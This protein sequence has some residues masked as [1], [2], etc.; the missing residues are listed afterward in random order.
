MSGLGLGL[1]LTSRAAAGGTIA[2]SVMLDSASVAEDANVGDL[3]GNLSVVGGSGSYTF[4]ITADPDSKF[5]LDG[6]DD[7]ILEVGGALDYETATS[8][9][10]T[11]EADNGVDDPISRQFT[12]QVTNVVETA[13]AQ[14]GAG[15]WSVADLGTNGDIAIT[16]ATLPDPGDGPITDLEYQVDGGGWSSLGDVVTGA[17]PLSGFTDGTE[18]DI[19]I[20]AVNAAGNGTASATK[21]VTPTGIPDAFEAADW[22]V[23][24]ATTGGQLDVTISSLPAANGS[25]VTDIEYRV[26]GG[27]WVSSGGTTDFSITGLTDDVEVDV[28]LQ[29][30]NANGDSG[31]GDLKSETPTTAGGGAPVVAWGTGEYGF[32]GD[33]IAVTSGDTTGNWQSSA[34]GST[35]WANISGETT[36]AGF[37][38]TAAYEG[39][40]VRWNDDT[41]GASNVPDRVWVPPDLGTSILKAYTD[42]ANEAEI[43]E[44]GGDVSQVDDVSGNGNDYAQGTGSLQPKTGTVALNS[45]NCLDFN[46]DY[47]GRADALGFTGSPAVTIVTLSQ[48]DTLADKAAVSVGQTGND[49][50]IAACPGEAKISFG[51]STVTF[52]DG[53]A[54][55]ATWLI[56]LF[57]HP[58]S[59]THENSYV[60]RNGTLLSLQSSSNGGN[61]LSM[62]DSLS[63]IGAFVGGAGGIRY[64]VALVMVL[65][66]EVSTA[67]REK[68]EGFIAHRYA[69]EGDL[70][71]GHTYKS[72]PPTV[73]AL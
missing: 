71:G 16:I 34:D 32:I 10:V 25:A 29:A 55:G 35:G 26:E 22:S 44:S 27:S 5:Q 72:T 42:F 24:D 31:A 68:I 17:Y 13:P 63:K 73:E 53:A 67:N 9:T 54:D 30:V 11:I 60:Y 51:G 45:L 33:V 56:D 12:I 58:A 61:S 70:P 46:Q 43:T 50:M 15:D 48:P 49:G 23:A 21:A 1:G 65:A 14:F 57:V 6:G 7:S 47:L 69:M 40:F 18:Y 8:H 2:A 20:R 19:A 28:E 36:A 38:Q 52:D 39:T 3:V 66:S 64:A 62:A 59:V 4:S 41:N 37:T